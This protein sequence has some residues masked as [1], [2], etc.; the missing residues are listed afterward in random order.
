[1]KLTEII[2][3]DLPEWAIE[4]M[5][6]GQLFNVAFKKYDRLLVL[7]TKHCPRDHNDWNEVVRL[8]WE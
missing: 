3:D 5:A 6:N 1:M 4:A 2:P 8:T 7:A